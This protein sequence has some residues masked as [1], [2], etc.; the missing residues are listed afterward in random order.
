M[1]HVF[2]CMEVWPS[3]LR[4]NFAKVEGAKAPRRFESCHFRVNYDN[5]EILI[6]ELELL[7]RLKIV[8]LRRSLTAGILVIPDEFEPATE[9]EYNNSLEDEILD[10]LLEPVHNVDSVGT[11]CPIFLRGP[12]DL[13]DKVRL[14]K[15]DDGSDL[16]HIE[17]RIEQ[18][19]HRLALLDKHE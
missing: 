15:F 1:K 11:I 18:V 8:T 3:G 16:E 17:S 12:A 6:E 7:D 14:I 19:K 13:L 9:E 10:A 5:R 4:R 2:C